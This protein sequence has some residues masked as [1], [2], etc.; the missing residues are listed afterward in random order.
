MATRFAGGVVKAYAKGFCRAEMDAH[1]ARNFI[2]QQR[3]GTR[4]TDKSSK[5]KLGGLG[6]AAQH[7]QHGNAR[8]DGRVFKATAGSHARVPFKG[9]G[10][11]TGLLAFDSFLISVGVGVG[12]WRL[13]SWRG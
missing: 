8:S 9:F 13:R 12:R 10:K 5:A 4:K 3:G 11:L 6:G 1:S 7:Q 2:D